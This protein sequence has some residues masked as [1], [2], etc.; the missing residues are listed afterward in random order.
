VEHILTKLYDILLI[1]LRL[2]FS[3]SEPCNKYLCL[4]N[5]LCN[6]HFNCWFGIICIPHWK[7][8]GSCQISFL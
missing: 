3:W 4:G 6:F 5:L 8:A 2:Q 1:F 7:Y